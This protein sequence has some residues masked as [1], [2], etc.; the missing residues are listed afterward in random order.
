MDDL[1]DALYLILRRYINNVSEPMAREALIRG[2]QEWCKRTL[3]WRHTEEYTFTG[4][5]DE[6]WYSPGESELVQIKFVKFDTRPLVAL[7]YDEY[8]DDLLANSD[9]SVPSY[10]CQR[11]P[12]AIQLIPYGAG[13]LRICAYLMPSVDGQGIMPREIISKFDTQ[14]VLAARV[15]LHSLDAMPY[16]DLNKSVGLQ[17]FLD[18]EVG[19]YA[20]F[21]IEGQING[22]RRDNY[23]FF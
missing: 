14:I 17:Q 22:R 15:Y 2:A 16:Y 19:K 5:E 23:S 21:N 4:D 6:F 9:D 20:N 8:L 12:N 7:A 13:T 10:Y 18:E 1:V 3:C 11:L